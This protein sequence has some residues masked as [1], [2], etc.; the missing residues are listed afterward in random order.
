MSKEKNRCPAVDTKSVS[1][2][3]KQQAYY[4]KIFLDLFFARRA[5]STAGAV[6]KHFD[7]CLLL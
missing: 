5:V 6:N 3:I 2:S 1:P 7:F 4:S